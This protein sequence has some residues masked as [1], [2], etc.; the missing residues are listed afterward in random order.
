[1]SQRWVF[2]KKPLLCWFQCS[3][4]TV[5][6]VK[7]GGGLWVTF[8]LTTLDKNDLWRGG[9]QSP[10]HALPQEPLAPRAQEEGPCFAFTRFFSLLQN[11]ISM[12]WL[13][14]RTS[15]TLAYSGSKYYKVL[16]FMIQ[17]IPYCLSCNSRKNGYRLRGA[18][19]ICPN[20][21]RY[22][23]GVSLFPYYRPFFVLPIESNVA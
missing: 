5:E 12:H 6:W 16:F 18:K 22:V 9:E 7:G 14:W 1:M 10:G 3:N 15:L 17:R 2:L 13:N 8:F 11:G 21:H 20:Q 23:E 19:L 4:R